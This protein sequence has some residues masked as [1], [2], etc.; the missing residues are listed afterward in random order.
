MKLLISAPTLKFFYVGRNL[1]IQQEG[2]TIVVER[3]NIPE[4][5]AAVE[6]VA[7]AE[8]ISSRAADECREKV[9]ANVIGLKS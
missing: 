7:S 3:A 2:K 5:M 9:V 4:A 1:V 8:N 6:Y